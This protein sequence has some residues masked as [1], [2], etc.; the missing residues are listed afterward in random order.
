MGSWQM[1]IGLLPSLGVLFSV[2]YLAQPS[3]L[4]HQEDPELAV[5]NSWLCLLHY[6]FIAPAD[7]VVR[8]RRR[9][10]PPALQLV[11]AP[12]L[13]L[14]LQLELLNCLFSYGIGDVVFC[15]RELEENTCIEHSDDFLKVLAHEMCSYFDRNSKLS[16]IAF[17]VSTLSL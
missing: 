17:E 2:K 6:F 13:L 5:E 1:G 8:H 4:L 12:P 14:S 7:A 11:I 9:M 3:P 15:L 16:F 10:R